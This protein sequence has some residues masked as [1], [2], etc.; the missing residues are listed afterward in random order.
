MRK[1]AWL[2]LAGMLVSGTA[3]IAQGPPMGYPYYPQPYSPMAPMGPM[4][5]GMP[6]Y[7]PPPAYPVNLTPVNPFGNLPP[8][9]YPAPISPGPGPKMGPSEPYFVQ[10]EKTPPSPAP[11]PAPAPQPGP[12]TMLPPTDGQSSAPAS[13]PVMLPAACLDA[14]PVEPYSLYEGRRYLAEVKQDCTHMWASAGYIHWWARR[15]NTP[16]LVTTGDP[17]NPTVGTLGNPDS[18]V[19]VGGGAIGPSEFS[20]FQTSLGFWCDDEH[21]NGFEIGG[22]YV[23]RT[24]RQYG[25][26]SDSAGSPALAFPVIISGTESSLIFAAPGLAAGSATVNNVMNFYGAEINHIHNAYRECGWSFDYFCGI[27]YVY[28]NDNLSMNDSVTV[29]P[30]GAGLASFLGAP[31]PAGANLQ[32]NDSFNVTNRFYGGQIGTRINWTSCKWDVGAILKV[33]LG[34]TTHNVAIDGSSTL[35]APT[36]AHAT[37]PGGIYAQPSN[38]G[39][40]SSTNFSVVPEMNL[41]VGYY[42]TPHV[43]LFVGY[44]ALYWSRVERAGDQIDRR[45]DPVQVPTSAAFAPGTAGTTPQFQNV[46]SD[47]W[48]Q[49]VNIGVELRY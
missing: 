41:N 45:V 18:V 47:F 37:A 27:R 40:F 44:N 39:S 16:P 26:G 22:F 13:G 30:G 2:A 48:A 8:R 29:L 31:Q 46:R 7:G 4:T 19:V 34:A 20:G 23:G 17:A 14:G 49:G 6:Y 21:T 43:R 15:G 35:I 28:L 9:S 42:V 32:M 1:K 36:G 38:I 24:S 10:P 11:T 5:P 12:K 3:A 33:A 25:A